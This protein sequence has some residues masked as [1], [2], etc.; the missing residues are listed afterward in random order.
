VSLDPTAPSAPGSAT[1]ATTPSSRGVVGGGEVR[2]TAPLLFAEEEG[3]LKEVLLAVD[4][5]R[6]GVRRVVTAAEPR[7]VF[8]A[9]AATAVAPV[10]ICA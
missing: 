6:D 5:F 7:P 10:G 3:L 8:G 9:Q 2:L 1:A 4:I